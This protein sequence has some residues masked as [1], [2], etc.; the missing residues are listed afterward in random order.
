LVFFGLFGEQVTLFIYRWLV[1]PAPF[2]L[3]GRYFG[4]LVT[5]AYPAPSTDW[6]YRQNM[7]MNQVFERGCGFVSF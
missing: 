1:F 4:D 5:V 6:Q 2:E 7:N 3:E